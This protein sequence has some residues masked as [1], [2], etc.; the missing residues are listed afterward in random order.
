MFFSEIIPILLGAII[1]FLVTISSQHQASSNH[2]EPFYIIR[3][4]PHISAPGS[5]QCVFP[6]SVDLQLTHTADRN[7]TSHK[8]DGPSLQDDK[9]VT[10]SHFS[11]ATATNLWTPQGAYT[12]PHASQNM[13]F[14]VTLIFWRR[15]PLILCDFLTQ[16]STSSPHLT[17]TK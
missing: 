10:N 8:T 4:F 9:I 11:W 15:I 6:G 1:I 14:E 5:Y 2:S 17:S 12:L 16:H 13:R 3:S 7:W